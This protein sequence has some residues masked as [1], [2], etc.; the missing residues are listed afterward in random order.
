MEV[1]AVANKLELKYKSKEKKGDW[2]LY[3]MQCRQKM[4]VGCSWEKRERGIMFNFV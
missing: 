4:F 3:V 2:L 1:T